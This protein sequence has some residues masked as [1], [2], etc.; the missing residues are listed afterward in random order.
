MTTVHEI[1]TNSA[2][3]NFVIGHDLVVQLPTLL[4]EVGIH[5][6]T[7]LFLI[8]DE[9]V[10]K[11]GFPSRVK[12]F[13]E[14]SGY[15][16]TAA[17]V[18]AGDESKSLATAE[19]LYGAMLETSLRRNGVILA[20]G[21]GMVGD[22]AGFVA[23]TYLR[24]IR[25]VQIPTTLLAHDSSIGGKV[26]VNLKIGKNLVG[27]FYHPEIVVYDVETLKS[28]PEREWAAGMAEVI[29]HGIIADELLFDRLE[30][31]PVPVY[32]GALRAEELIA[33]ASLVKIAIVEQ[34]EREQGVRMKLN[35]GHTVGHAVEQWSEYKV[36]HGE[37]VSMGISVETMLAVHR[38]LLNP[39]E[40]D[41]I[42]SV[43]RKHG[44]PISPPDVPLD[45][46]I[47]NMSKDKKHGDS[48]WTFAIPKRVGDV[49]ILSDVTVE[50][51]VRAWN[52][53]RNEFNSEGAV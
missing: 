50:E 2:A 33:Q 6:G 39:D 13:C 15:H 42:N 5:K 51:V 16:T 43:L 14:A 25:F 44:L 7:H 9:N 46:L 12:T 31:D 3:Y 19:Q 35:L 22:L 20:L 11:T 21:G 8:T 24:G 40:R 27:A 18:R 52:E 4:A 29:K 45:V 32:P 48:L 28:L 1:R 34:D 23:A 36:H 10:A 53:T 47:E 26:G 38:G 49:V 37:A 30:R 41:R 17:V